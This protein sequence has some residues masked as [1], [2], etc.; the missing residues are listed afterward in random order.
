MALTLIDPKLVFAAGQVSLDASG[1]L[2]GEGDLAA[3][4]EPCHL[5]ASTALAAA[6]ASFDDVAK[7]TAYVVDRTPDKL[8]S[9]IDRIARAAG[10]LRTNPVPPFTLIGVAALAS[11]GFLVELEVTAVLE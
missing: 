11:P 6:E 7:L 5:N 9:M 3:Q 10:K 1:E 4:V 8:S 2:V